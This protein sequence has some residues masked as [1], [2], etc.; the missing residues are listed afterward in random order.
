LAKVLQKNKTNSD[1]HILFSALYKVSSLQGASYRLEQ[2]GGLMKLSSK[3]FKN[4]GPKN[5]TRIQGEIGKERMG[6]E[7]FDVP[8]K[9]DDGDVTEVINHTRDVSDR[10][11]LEDQLIAQ[12]KVAAVVELASGIAHEIRNPLGNISASA[13]YFISKYKPPKKSRK[14]LNIILKNANYANGIITDLLNFARPRETSFEMNDIR[15][16]IDNTLNLVKGRCLKQKVR[17]TCRLEEKLPKIMLDT[18][19]L[20]D[21]FLN[22]IINALDAM[23]KGGKLTISCHVNF[24]DSEVEVSFLDTGK[25]IPKENVN[26]IFDPFFTTKRNGT[27][28]GLG[29]ALQAIKDHKGKIDVKSKV[30]QGTEVIVKL[31]ISRVL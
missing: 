9:A 21:A 10:I 15:R 4:D 11:N 7:I 31:P 25:G 1:I 23:P 16:V 5:I 3:T 20:E 19:R 28:L 8:I 22:I 29:L 14:Y 13:Q 6:F 26:R 24:Q 18:K 12:A 2:K 17:L 30:S 27:G